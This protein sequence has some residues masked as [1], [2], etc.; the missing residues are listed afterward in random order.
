MG[1][2]LWMPCTKDL[3]NQGLVG[4]NPTGTCTYEDGKI[5]NCA[6]VTS[7]IDTGL[8]SDKWDYSTKSISFGGWFKFNKAEMQAAVLNKST[9]TNQRHPSFNLLGKNSYNG[10]ALSLSTNNIYNPT[11]DLTSLN[12]QAHMRSS[13]ALWSCSFGTIEWDTWI[14]LFITWDFDSKTFTAYKNGAKVNS[15]TIP[16]WGG[17]FTYRGAFNIAEKTVF[18]GNGPAVIMPFRVNDVRVYDHCLSIRELKFIASALVLHYPLNDAY[19]QST[20][21]LNKSI[22]INWDNWGTN[23]V[24]RNSFTSP[25][26]TQGS[27]VNC[28]SFTSGGVYVSHSSFSVKPSTTYV[29]SAKMKL[30]GYTHPNLFYWREY[31]SSNTKLSESGKWSST[32]FI[33][34]G[35]GYKLYY[36]TVTTSSTTSSVSLQ[37]YLY[38]VGE[39]WIYDIQVE[40]G[41]YPTP[42][43]GYNASRTAT[44]VYDCSGYQNNGTISGS[45]SCVA[46]SSRYKISTV[47]DGISSKII[48]DS[49][50]TSIV[51]GTNSFTICGWAYYIKGNSYNPLFHIGS[52]YRDA[53]GI[54]LHGEGNRIEGLDING[55]KINNTY[56]SGYSNE[57]WVHQCIVYDGTTIKRYLNGNSTPVQSIACPGFKSD[58]NKLCVGGFWG[59]PFKGYLS[60]FRIYATALSEEDIKELYNT[61][62]YV[63]DNGTLLTYNLEE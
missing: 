36:G 1:L 34:Y 16:N 22:G 48:N 26:G 19:V 9:N 2:V 11:A 42:F 52:A 15:Y 17:N 35:H 8:S 12:I 3:H 51:S 45:L 55:T 40:E 30:T 33:E 46:N 23:T 60:D 5:G 63:L 59:V 21:N 24:T 57:K 58:N 32:R 50:P 41:T 53:T 47:F 62:A 29:I 18:G 44:T 38:G 43:A 31:D 39:H 10:F 7:T 27:H 54:C 13:T 25:E 61:S 37:S 14:H 4:T 6:K 28:S 56:G 20:T 49:F